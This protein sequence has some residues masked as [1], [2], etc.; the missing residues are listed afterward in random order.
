AGRKLA[1]RLAH[2][3]STL[4]TPIHWSA[5]RLRRH[6]AGGPPAAKDLVD[7]CAATIVG[8][9]ESLK[10]LVDEFS[11]FARMPAPRTVPTDLGQL[12]ADTLVLY[13]DIFTD[14]RIEQ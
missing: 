3:T 11:Q 1:R 4:L 8:E 2:K 7:E 9:V 14:V 10:D 13:N 5:E 12:V 6:F